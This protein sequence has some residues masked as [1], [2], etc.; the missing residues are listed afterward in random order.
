[1]KKW[2]SCLLVLLLGLGLTPSNAAGS[3]IQAPLELHVE[4][5]YIYNSK[6]EK[7]RLT[8]LNIPDL[9]WATGGDNDWD[10]RLALA[11]DQWNANCIRL[12]VHSKF[13]F[14]NEWYQNG[15]STGYRSTVDRII[16][17]TTARG[18]YV[19]L[20]LHEFYAITEENKHFW[21]DA[22]QTYKN[23][24]GVIFGLLNEP[25]D[26]SW[27]VWRN[28]GHITTTDTYGKTYEMPVYGHQQI[29]EMIRGLGAKNICIAGGLDWSYYFDGITKG[30]DGLENGYRLEE[31]PAPYTGNGI[32]YDTHIYPMKPEYNPWEK[33]ISCVVDDV[34]I[35]VGEYG[36]WGERLFDW[37]D[38]YICEYPYI[39]MNEI[40]DYID[41]NELN[42][43]AW[44]FH[45]GAAPAMF[46]N[47]NT[48][49]PTKH[50]GLVQKFALIKNTE[51]TRPPEEERGTIDPS[52]LST[53][54]YELNFDDKTAEFLVYGDEVKTEKTADG[55]EG[56]G[57]LVSFNITKGKEGKSAAIYE[58]PQNTDLSGAKWLSVRI[59][60]DGDQRNL[61][62][63]IELQ[64]GRQFICRMPIDLQTNWK[65]WFLPLE[66]F[67]G[68]VGLLD[69]TKIK[70][71]FMTSLDEGPGSFTVDNLTVGGVPY[72]APVIG[73][74]SNAEQEDKVSWK[75]WADTESENP[76]SFTVVSADGKVKNGGAVLLSYERPEGSYGGQA[77]MTV[78]TSWELTDKDYFMFWA[79]GDG[80]E[81]SFTLRFDL[82]KGTNIN[83]QRSNFK[84]REFERFC[85]DFTV[86]GSEWKL[87]K[88][89]FSDLGMSDI[90]HKERI[91]FVDFF[92]RME[93]KKGSVIIDNFAF[94]NEQEPLTETYV[95]HEAPR[96]SEPVGTVR[97][98]FP[99][100]QILQFPKTFEAI[101]GQ[102][103]TI[104]IHL[105]N[106]T[107]ANAAGLL[108]VEGVP[109]EGEITQAKYDTYAGYVSYPH[110]P[111]RSYSYSNF[112]FTVPK[113]KTGTYT[114]TVSD[115]AENGPVV[116]QEYKLIV[117][118]AE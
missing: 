83:E 106:K 39:W 37:Y 27:D 56:S 70:A 79:K 77:R 46:T 3:G 11:L 110:Y 31:P 14:G 18:K 40:Q 58:L 104:Q 97:T 38:N 50:S 98:K 42:Y 2:I 44:S 29:L 54:E 32:I 9:Q 103:V 22:A 15:D 64:D 23:N 81:Q 24:P 34:P 90:L 52:P 8:G 57:Q 51:D 86:S 17:Q 115:A 6:G 85:L 26:I 61:G 82:E 101:A 102:P 99:Q 117:R 28:G 41:R 74:V 84:K 68:D 43:T 25:H 4:G 105:M 109:T 48:F 45:I 93:N 80:T 92:N 76:D 116:P 55:Y 91:R 30:Y 118:P 63:G 20:N 12:C 95:S 96:P 62:F 7:V 108:K 72:E 100:E 21:E 60:G 49:E 88:F 5:R 1:M 10:K 67:Y 114:I 71:L 89:R 33:A 69:T 113:E 78:P 75:A 59:K 16:R 36:H 73:T 65:H 66:A 107:N 53:W 111:W 112:T 13:W 47:Y 19:I 94:T 87:Y 35:L